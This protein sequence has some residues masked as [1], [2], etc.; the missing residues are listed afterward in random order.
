MKTDLHGVDENGQLSEQPGGTLEYKRKKK[1][2][3][4]KT[5]ATKQR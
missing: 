4:K 5:T 3:T 2:A 1:Q